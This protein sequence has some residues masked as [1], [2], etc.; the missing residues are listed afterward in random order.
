MKKLFT[1]VFLLSTS[2]LANTNAPLLERTYS[3]GLPMG[4]AGKYIASQCQVF[5]EYVRTI[6]VDLVTGERKKF[7]KAIKAESTIKALIAKAAHGTPKLEIGPTD[8]PSSYYYAWTDASPEHRF[9][10]KA[11]GSHIGE[12]TML[13]ATKLIGF[14]DQVCQSN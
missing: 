9:V 6:T 5:D 1:I 14:T 2:S 7:E 4:G 8:V 12:N 3:P 10:L 13:E 11:T